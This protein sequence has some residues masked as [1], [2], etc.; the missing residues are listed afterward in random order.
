MLV[1]FLRHSEENQ[2]FLEFAVSV[3][4]TVKWILQ[5]N[6]WK[7][8]NFSPVSASEMKDHITITVSLNLQDV[9]YAEDIYE[10]LTTFQALCSE[11][12]KPVKI[13]RTCP[14]SVC[15]I[16]VWSWWK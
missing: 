8:N 11:A 3:D 13:S 12:E 15:D 6:F 14:Y 7:S 9:C 4:S 1:P 16:N 2:I 10:I 5:E